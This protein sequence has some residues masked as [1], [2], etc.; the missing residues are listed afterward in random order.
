VRA[1]FQALTGQW[2]DTGGT[3]GAR[4]GRRR[5]ACSV[6]G[7]GFSF[8]HFSPKRQIINPGWAICLK[9]C[10]LPSST[11]PLPSANQTRPDLTQQTSAAPTIPQHHRRAEYT[12]V[13]GHALIALHFRGFQKHEPPPLPISSSLCSSGPS[14]SLPLPR[15]NSHTSPTKTRIACHSSQWT[16]ALLRPTFIRTEMEM[17][18]PQPWMAS[19]R[20]RWVS[21]TPTA[22]PVYLLG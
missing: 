7:A 6:V 4:Q 21:P 19:K 22:F 16:L 8:R 5:R 9:T 17:P 10:S 18:L 13:I 2:A 1:V 15:P 3:C 12:F 14:S 20:V 11:S